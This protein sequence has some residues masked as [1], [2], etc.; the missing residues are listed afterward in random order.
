M[1]IDKFNFAGKKAIVRVDFNVPLDENGKITDD[2]RIRGA[3]P[4]LKK[5][6]AD[7]G[8]LIIMSHM[9]K[10]KGKVNAKYSLSQIVD[11]VSEKLGVPVQFAP[12]CAKAGDAAAALK[13]GE[14]LLLENLR[15]Y[16]E[17]EGKPVGIDKED[18]AYEDAK[19]AM[20][21]SQKNLPRLWLLMLIA[22]S[23]TH[24]VL[25]TVNMLLQLLCRLFRCRQQDVGLFDG[26][27]SSS[28]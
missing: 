6:L 21:A 9:G 26:K 20:K 10:P 28:C 11:A 3:L 15:F 22:I 17:E 8:S 16:P 4:T 12:D 14:V 1:T 2:T 27:R 19:K 5:V 18:P 23:M 24:S 13:P 7:G 25:L